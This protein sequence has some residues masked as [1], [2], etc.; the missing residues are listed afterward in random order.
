MIPFWVTT[1]KRDT[2]AFFEEHI[3]AVAKLIAKFDL[4]A[5]EFVDILKFPR[6][7]CQYRRECKVAV[8]YVR[9]KNGKRDKPLRHTS[10]ISCRPPQGHE[11]GCSHTID[12]LAMFMG[13][14]VGKENMDDV[15]KVVAQSE[16]KFTVLTAR[17]NPTKRGESSSLA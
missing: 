13:A 10:A 6:P 2:H 3:L 14:R 7:I 4:V 15:V 1:Q 5:L 16:M 12:R 8:V 11:F 9:R 17:L